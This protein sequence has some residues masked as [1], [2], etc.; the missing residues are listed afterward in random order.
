MLTHRKEQ[1]RECFCFTHYL[2]FAM[3]FLC[4]CTLNA[5]LAVVSK[6]SCLQEA[7]VSLPD[8][9]LCNCIS[10]QGGQAEGILAGWS[11]SWNL[12]LCLRNGADEERCLPVLGLPGLGWE[13]SLQICLLLSVLTFIHFSLSSPSS[14]P[15]ISCKTNGIVSNPVDASTMQIQVITCLQTGL[16]NTPVKH[17]CTIT[18][19]LW[20][21]S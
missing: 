17:P 20:K 3:H 9:S 14:L 2:P 11:Q 8:G 7:Q 12:P 16:A 15:T 10:K 4:L 19:R 13:G 6:C 5:L 18:H 21:E 1:K